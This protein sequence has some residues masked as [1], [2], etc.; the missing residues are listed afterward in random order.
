MALEIGKKLAGKVRGGIPA[1]SAPGAL[2]RVAPKAAA[3]LQKAA[4]K[5]TAAVSGAAGKIRGAVSGAAQKV[6]SQGVAGAVGSTV[7]NLRR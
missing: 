7:K 6:E 4:P 5:A 3:A 1:K 2:Q